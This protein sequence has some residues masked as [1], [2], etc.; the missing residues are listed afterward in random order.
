[1]SERPCIKT[2]KLCY[3]STVEF[4]DLVKLYSKLIFCIVEASWHCR[5]NF[6]IEEQP[7]ERETNTGFVFAQAVFIRTLVY[8]YS[9]IVKIL[10]S[11]LSLPV[12]FCNLMA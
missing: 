2:I 3:I 7:R 4:L 10:I 12:I 6:S 5:N 1:M 9:A 11:T 8:L